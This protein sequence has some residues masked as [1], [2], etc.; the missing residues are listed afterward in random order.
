[1]RNI[2]YRI[3]KRKAGNEVQFYVDYKRFADGDDLEKLDRALLEKCGIR[4]VAFA[5]PFGAYDENSEA[6]V[7]AR[8]DAAFTCYERVNRLKKGDKD[9]L[10]RLYRI[11]RDGTM[12]TDTF[13]NLHKIA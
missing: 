8:Y 9:K 7:K 10:W 4:P 5:Y 12:S 13:L 6:M 1:M 11:N 2:E 3:R